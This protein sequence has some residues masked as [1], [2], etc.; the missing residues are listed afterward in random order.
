[1]VDIVGSED[2]LSSIVVWISGSVLRGD[3]DEDDDDEE[4]EDDE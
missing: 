3:D 2:K 1:M 4:D